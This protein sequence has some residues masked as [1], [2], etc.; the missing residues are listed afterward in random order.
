[1]G[2]VGVLWNLF[3]QSANVGLYRFN[4]VVQ[5]SVAKLA[6]KLTKI[7]PKKVRFSEKSDE[8]KAN[9]KVSFFESQK[10]NKKQV[11]FL[12]KL[13]KKLI[14]FLAFSNPKKL[15]KK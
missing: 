1:M 7:F 5:Q 10:A 15:R 11:S 9:K 6:K 12:K 8:A 2:G 3:P 4:V 14:F 13:R